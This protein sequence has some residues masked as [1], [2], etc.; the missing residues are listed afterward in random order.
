MRTRLLILGVA[1]AV[2]LG[3]CSSGTHQSA[4]PTS[5]SAPSTT[6]VPA[7]DAPNP[8]VIPPV[9]TV[10]YV[11]AVFAVLNHI[12]GDAVRA[13]LLSR[14]VTPIV[15][16]YLRAIYNDP[17]YAQEVNIAR[18]SLVGNLNNVRQPT[19]DLLTNVKQLIAAS[20]R[21]VFVQTQT[22]FS[23][24][25]IRPDPTAASEYFALTPKQPGADPNHQNP[26]PWALKF[27]ADY[28]TPTTI[29]DQCPAS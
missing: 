3:A 27:N 2:A 28:K 6:A 1:V 14:A 22:D 9:I 29:P 13:L 12:N 8:D 15:E 4:P 18:Q 11:N 10:A 21:C 25:L 19:G 23:Q 16:T 7:S 5:V 20:S 24:V 26:T 17:L